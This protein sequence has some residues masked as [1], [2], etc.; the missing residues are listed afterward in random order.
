MYYNHNLIHS[1]NLNSSRSSNTYQIPISFTILLPE[2]CRS[3]HI[4]LYI[5]PSNNLI[6]SITLSLISNTQF[7]TCRQD[8]R[9]L[10]TYRCSS[11]SNSNLILVKPTR[12]FLLADPKLSQI[13]QWLHHLQLTIL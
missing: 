10:T 11:S 4:I 2:L 7:T 1:N 5:L 6:L 13:R 9:S 12:P 3:Q 8:R